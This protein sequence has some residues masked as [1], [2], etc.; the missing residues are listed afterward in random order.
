MDYIDGVNDLLLHFFINDE[1]SQE[2]AIIKIPKGT[3]L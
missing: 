3:V 2:V 1:A